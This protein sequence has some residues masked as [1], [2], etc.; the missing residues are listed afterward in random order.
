M[1]FDQF[2]SE[3][4]RIFNIPELFDTVFEKHFIKKL[5]FSAYYDKKASMVGLFF[6]KVFVLVDLHMIEMPDRPNLQMT[7]GIPNYFNYVN[8]IIP[9]PDDRWM[10]FL[11][12][13]TYGAYCII[14]NVSMT[15]D[16]AFMF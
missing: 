14:D 8:Q 3:T 15:S 12:Y 5:T 7:D 16:V 9:L 6:L 1:S 13:S 10:V 4:L 11:S 2:H